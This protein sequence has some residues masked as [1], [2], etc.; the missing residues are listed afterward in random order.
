MDPNEREVRHSP[1]LNANRSLISRSRRRCDC[2]GNDWS[3][4]AAQG[5]HGMDEAETAVG[6]WQST[7]P[8]VRVR[9]L[10]GHSNCLDA[11][12]DEEE[13]LRSPG[14][15]TLRQKLESCAQA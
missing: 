4:E 11:K 5:E 8:G 12:A 3:N 15:K 14:T 7:C 6:I 9:V 2:C 13:G 1:G 10:V